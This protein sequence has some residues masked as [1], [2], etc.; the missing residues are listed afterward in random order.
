MGLLWF[1]L[2]WSTVLLVWHVPN[3]T[4]K[5][6]IKKKKPNILFVVM[7]DLGSHDLGRHGSG[8]HTHHID[9]LATDGVYLDNYYV[10]PYCSP[11]RAALLSGRYP[12]HTGVHIV[13]PVD[14]VLSLPLEEQTLAQIM[15]DGG[16]K[17]H[18]VGKWHIGH[19]NW[20]MTPT[21]RGFETFFGFYIGGEDYFTHRNGAGYDLRW[22]KEEYCGDGCSQLPDE[23]G[24]YST[25][26][27]TREAIRVIHRHSS[28]NNKK[29]QQQIDE[30][31]PL[32][33][34][35]AYQAVH[36]PDQVPEEYRAPYENVTG[37]DAR[38]ITYAGMLT[39]A[40]Q[41]IAQ[42]IEALQETGMWDD[43][44][45]VFT[46][47]NG[48]P[49]DVCAIQGSSNFP[50]RGGKCTLYD[51]GTTGDGFISGP[52]LTSH[53]AVPTGSDRTY[54]NLFHAV[55]WLPT[56]AAAVGVTP[57]GQ[58]LDGVSHLYAFQNGME[59][60]YGPPAPMRA[61][62]NKKIAS[63]PPRQEVF[64]GYS[65]YDHS[66][67]QWYG[68]AIRYHHWK[69]IQGHSGG[70]EHAHTP[71]PK[72]TS[73]PAPG[74]DVNATYLLFDLSNDPNETRDVAR[75]HPHVVALLMGR[76][77]E[78]QKHYVGPP[79]NT[80]PSCPFPGLRNH[81]KFG[82]VWT[83]WCGGTSSRSSTYGDD[84]DTKWVPWCDGAK[85]VRI[86]T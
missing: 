74:G 85:E 41:G 51:G 59:E 8:I 64:V 43:T 34:Y 49:T 75:E 68:P 39:A 5:T 62:K 28:N 67:G 31:D 27:F 24:N 60:L 71:P 46:T 76:L 70:P 16:Y 40:D 38:R 23:R 37:W 1:F 58:P 9:Q 33:L 36:D 2:V 56:L 50:K 61:L 52:A 15:R 82:K 4:A 80:D 10:L 18:A 29:K 54:A 30:E 11:T 83:P 63:A 6:N 73:T 55:D 81:S 13:V 69:L 78:Y 53:W 17:A 86:Y 84:D 22:D 72:G 66:G 3:S 35:L 14:S 65:F 26:V 25:Q 44:V 48:G 45:V 42:V 47:D 7:D 19:A 77:Q 12:L 21:F 57:N 79:P 32:F 20:K